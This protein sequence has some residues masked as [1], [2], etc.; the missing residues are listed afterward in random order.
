[1][2]P[3]RW[4]RLARALI[5]LAVLSGALSGCATLSTE[6]QA[7]ADQTTA[8][9]L[10]VQQAQQVRAVVNWQATGRMAIRTE[11]TGGSVSFDWRQ[12][13]NTTAL[14]LNAPLN[15][16]TLTLTGTPDLMRIEDSSGQSRITQTPDQTLTRLTGRHIPIRALPD[17][18]R[19]LPHTSSAQ[20]LFNEQ[21]QLIRLHDEGW[22]LHYSG[23]RPA[24]APG[25]MMPTEITAEHRDIHL[26]MIIDQWQA[27]PSS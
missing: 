26:R 19:A 22:T 23:Y 13:Q 15:Q 20:T 16:G 1:M 25:L 18:I 14:V 11:Q 24:L 4:P 7:A 17:W 12:R 5:G 10:F 9:Q 6:P 3:P 2:N 8:A 21:G 27:L